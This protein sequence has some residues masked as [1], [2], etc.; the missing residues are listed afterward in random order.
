MLIEFDVSCALDHHLGR[1]G[2]DL[3]VEVC[4]QVNQGLHDALNVYDHGFHC[5]GHDGQFLVQEVPSSRYALAHQDFI[6][7]AANP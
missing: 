7:R 5:T 3:G 4:S 6:G 1:G 2:D